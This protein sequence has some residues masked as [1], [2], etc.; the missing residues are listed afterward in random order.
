MRI[1][2]GEVF[3]TVC[4]TVKGLGSTSRPAAF[5]EMESGYRISHSQ[6]PGTRGILISQPADAVSMTCPPMSSALRTKR[7]IGCSSY[8]LRFVQRTVQRTSG[9]GSPDFQGGS[10]D[11]VTLRVRGCDDGSSVRPSG[12]SSVTAALRTLKAL[13]LRMLARMS[14]GFGRYCPFARSYARESGTWQKGWSCS[15]SSGGTNKVSPQ[16]QPASAPAIDAS[17]DSA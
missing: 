8:G 17:V 6:S 11:G 3:V 4:R 7:G 14:K 13:W 1:A 16:G 10:T 2:A 12:S 15:P 9:S 5:T